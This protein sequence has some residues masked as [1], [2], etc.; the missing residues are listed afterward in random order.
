[1]EVHMAQQWTVRFIDDLDGSD[2]SGTFDFSLEGRAYQIDLSDD[3]AAKLRDALDPSL[4]QREAVP[5]ELDVH[6]ICD[7]LATHKTPAIRNWLARHPRFH[8]HF[9]PTGSSWINQVERG[10]GCSPTNSSG[11]GSTTASSPS[12][13]TSGN[14]STTGTRTRNR[15]SGPRPPKT[16]C[17]P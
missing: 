12:R 2:A 6:L 10:S 9:T 15:S 4:V 5:A 3:N 16:S 14:G 8:L 7:N 11:A 17:S 1:M 13:T